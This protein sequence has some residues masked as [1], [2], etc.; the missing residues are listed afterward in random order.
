M[1]VCAA[2]TMVFLLYLI[3]AAATAAVGAAIYVY[4]QRPVLALKL[5][6]R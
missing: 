5:M 1:E 6:M 3:V 4:Y 2:S